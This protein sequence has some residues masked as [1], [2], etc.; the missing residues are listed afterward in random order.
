MISVRVHA[1]D[2]IVDQQLP[3]EQISDVLQHEH[4]LVWVDVVSPTPDELRLLEQEFGFHPLS[5]EDAILHQ[6]RPKLDQYDDFLLIIFYAMVYEVAEARIDL[7]QISIFTGSNYVVTVHERELLV[8]VE[9]ANRWRANHRRI[10]RPN[11]GMLVYA[12]LDSIVD[13]YLPVVDQLSDR[14]DQIEDSIFG[15]FEATAQ[16]EMFR[17]KRDLLHIR[18]VLG[19]ERDVL[20]LLMRRDTPVYSDEMVRYFQ[21]IYD[22]LLRVQDSIDT[23]RDL[24]SSALD[25]YLSVISNRMNKVMKTLTASSIILMGMTL[26]AGIYGMNFDHMPELDWLLGYPLALGLMATVGISLGI[27][28]KQIDWL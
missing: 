12:I 17:L 25:S 2:Q 11:A 20:N 21:D 27:L 28:F 4:A 14:I 13:D 24:L 9:T 1:E 3:L 18:R 10:A 6:E 16:Q 22:H 15:R 7:D 23:F 19:P 26:I 8:L 5:L